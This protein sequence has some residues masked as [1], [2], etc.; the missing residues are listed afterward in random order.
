[1]DRERKCPRME[2]PFVNYDWTT[3]EAFGFLDQRVHERKRDASSQIVYDESRFPPVVVKYRV[4]IRSYTIDDGVTWA[5]CA[6]GRDDCVPSQVD[7]EHAPV[8]EE[9]AGD[10]GEDVDEGDW[11]LSRADRQVPD[12]DRNEQ[13][14]LFRRVSEFGQ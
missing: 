2:E 13:Q 9:L 3:E 5:H 1:M 6:P 12:G 8:I 4:G 11:D 14:V 7:M 10:R